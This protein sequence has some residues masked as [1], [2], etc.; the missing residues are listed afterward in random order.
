MWQ[1]LERAG[2]ATQRVSSCQVPK[3]GAPEPDTL[4]TAPEW[5]ALIGSERR[6][7]VGFVASKQIR[8]QTEDKA[9]SQAEPAA[10]HLP[11]EWRRSGLVVC[12]CGSAGGEGDFEDDGGATLRR[13]K[14]GC[15]PP[16]LPQ[17]Y[18]VAFFL[19]LIKWLASSLSGRS[20]SPGP[21]PLTVVVSTL[22]GLHL[23]PPEMSNDQADLNSGIKGHC[24][25][26][27]PLGQEYSSGA[28]N[29]S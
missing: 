9:M 24:S 21:S 27:A 2:G 25:K 11:F 7:T 1:F 3:D 26:Y 8:I 16:T 12:G 13:P 29:S 17:A 5:L 15:D 4:G 22:S 18:R 6:N 23:K 10:T 14:C 19:C 28:S 20:G